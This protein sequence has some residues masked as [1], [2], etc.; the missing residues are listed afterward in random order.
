MANSA[1]K[2]SKES[3]EAVSLGPINIPIPYSLP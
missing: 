2:R 1:I 3:I